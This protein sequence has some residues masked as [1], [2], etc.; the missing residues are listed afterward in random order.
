MDSA[1]KITNTEGAA[2]GKK[3]RLEKEES[4]QETYKKPKIDDSDSDLTSVDS[5]ELNRIYAES[6]QSP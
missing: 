4:P 6:G 1:G 2:R 3:R 5:A